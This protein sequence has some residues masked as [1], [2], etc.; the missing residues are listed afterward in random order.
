MKFQLEQIG[1]IDPLIV[2]EYEETQN[3]FEFLSAQSNDLQ[4]ASDSLREVI[5]EL[6]RKIEEIF[7]GSFRKINEEFDKYFKIIFGGGKANLSIKYSEN[8]EDKKEEEGEDGE[9]VEGEN[10]DSVDGS[11]KT[12]KQQRIAGIEINVTPPGKKITSL[13]MLSGGERALASIAVLFAII[14]NN[15]PPFSVLDEIDAAL[16]EANSAKLSEI[17]GDVSQDTQFIVITHNREMMKQAGVL[18]GVTMTDDGV[19]R[20]ISLNLEDVGK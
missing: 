15:P 3:R 11:E 2:E 13:N 5:K 19:S 4:K 6:D 20:I 1:G 18:Y 8:K 7:K 12:D 9:S 16:D 14:A 17:I 10:I